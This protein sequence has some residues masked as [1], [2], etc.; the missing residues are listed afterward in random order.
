[1]RFVS[2]G[3]AAFELGHHASAKGVDEIRLFGVLE[4][5]DSKDAAECRGA[6]IVRRLREATR[7]AVVFTTAGSALPSRLLGDRLAQ[8]QS[9]RMRELLVSSE[10]SKDDGRRTTVASRRFTG[11][12][13][14]Q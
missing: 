14:E 6:D 7:D 9:P 1:M 11:T 13:D 3:G 4:G 2:C 8:Q 10:F 5:P 12:Y